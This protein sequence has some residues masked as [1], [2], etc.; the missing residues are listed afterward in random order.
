MLSKISIVSDIQ[1]LQT[2][3]DSLLDLSHRNQLSFN[4]CKFVFMTFH[5]KFNSEYNINGHSLSQPISCKDLGVILTNTLS[6]RQHYNMI[7]SKAYNPLVSC[8]EYLRTHTVLR[9]EN[10]S[11]YQLLEL[12]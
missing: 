5:R 2:D 7:I 8:T 12:T 3:L 11:I 1:Q 6:R 4:V 9:Q 10:P